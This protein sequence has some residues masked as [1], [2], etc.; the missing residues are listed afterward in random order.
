MSRLNPM[1]AMTS[2]STPVLSKRATMTSLTSQPS[3]SVDTSSVATS[4]ATKGQRSTTRKSTIVNAGSTTNSPCAKLIVF[5]VCHSSTNPI[6][7]MA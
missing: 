6:A 2:G 4:A 1:V 5:D 7:V 3:S